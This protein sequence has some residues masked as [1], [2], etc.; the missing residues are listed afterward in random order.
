MKAKLVEVFKQLRFALHL[1]A[2]TTTISLMI[3]LS[4]AVECTLPSNKLNFSTAPYVINM[5]ADID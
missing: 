3:N 4:N 1:L 2:I 5:M